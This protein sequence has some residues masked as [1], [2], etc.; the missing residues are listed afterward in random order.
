[1]HE[2]TFILKVSRNIRSTEILAESWDLMDSCQK[3]K[4]YAK[5]VVE[6]DSN[7]I[8]QQCV[9][10]VVLATCFFAGKVSIDESN[11]VEKIVGRLR[12]TTGVLD[13]AREVAVR[14]DL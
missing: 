10:K 8:V 5:L 12:Q 14:H 1:M 9:N 13:L 2:L 3:V 11:G 6:V 4:G 7:T